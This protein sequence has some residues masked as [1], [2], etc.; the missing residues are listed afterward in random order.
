MTT[1]QR[2]AVDNM[3]RNSGMTM[4]WR[5]HL[6][7]LVD[8]VL[9]DDET[10]RL[11]AAIGALIDARDDT[12]NRDVLLAQSVD[13]LVERVV[14]G[15][16]A[17]VDT[18]TEQAASEGARVESA[19][20]AAESMTLALT[21]LGT[22]RDSRARACADDTFARLD[23]IIV[24]LVEQARS[25]GLDPALA[26]YAHVAA[27]GR[28]TERERADELATMYDTA[29]RAQTVLWRSIEDRAHEA[30]PAHFQV[31]ARLAN[32]LD[33]CEHY[34]VVSIGSSVRDNATG[35]V[36]TPEYPWPEL[37]GDP[38]AELLWFAATPNAQHWVPSSR[39]LGAAMDALRK[40]HLAAHDQ[41]ERAAHDAVKGAPRPKVGTTVVRP[42][43]QLI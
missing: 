38:L 37:G 17:A 29:R 13:T 33:V 42:V 36:S 9:A 24:D 6:P 15:D 32:V 19:R 30:V 2:F 1:D 11:N 39:R 10:R 28:M 43:Q 22:A 3:A 35:V 12:P 31:A 18:F 21:R 14:D 26:D 34:G 40:A 23:R 25:E 20:L 4:L 5:S 16:D 8:V 41:R 27:A 7:P